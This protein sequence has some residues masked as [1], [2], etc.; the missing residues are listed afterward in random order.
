MGGKST[1]SQQT[2]Q[3]TKTEQN[4]WE[5]TIG[6]LKQ[7]ISGIAGQVGNY[8]PNAMELQAI[9][10]LRGNAANANNYAP[11]TQSLAN[12]LYAGGPDRTG[13]VND[14][15]GAYRASAQPYL[16]PEFLDPYKNPAFQNYMSTI[17]ND[18]QGR[19]SGMY[20]GAGRDPVGA[21]NFGQNLARGI[22]EGTAP[23]FAN[24]YNQN[25]ATQRGMMDNLYNAGGQTAQNLSLLDQ[26][27]LGNRLQGA[28]VA[29]SLLP[30][31]EDANANRA[32]S[33][34]SAARG[35]PL[36]NLGLLSGLLGQLAGLGGTG[37]S[38]STGTM[39]GQN[40]MS[41]AQQFNLIANGIGSLWPK[42]PVKFG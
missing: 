16:S 5:P 32:L 24:Q 4:P 25:V 8:Q 34:E 39:T 35:L 27:A 26:T 38:N 10:T 37:T 41:G 29:G 28:N 17:G 42:A 36:A 1:T 31:F 6:P 23:I 9:N 14:S 11:Q 19:L 30:A 18:I 20:A 3:K 33:A 13:I 21:G 22:T 40:Q 12:D 7:V 15:Y 2:Q